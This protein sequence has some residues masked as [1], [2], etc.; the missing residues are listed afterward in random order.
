MNATAFI[1]RDDVIIIVVSMRLLR[2]IK[3]INFVKFVKV[4]KIVNHINIVKSLGAKAGPILAPF[5][6]IARHSAQGILGIRLAELNDWI[7]DVLYL[8]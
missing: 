5:H 8:K 7:A 3:V 1:A 4:I 6:F 2:F